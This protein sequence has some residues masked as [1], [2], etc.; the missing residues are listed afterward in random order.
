MT[1]RTDPWM[2]LCAD[3]AC[4]ACGKNDGTVV[5][6]HANEQR[7]GKGMGIK[8]D[9]WTVIALCA[10]HH[11][12]LDHIATREEARDA[13][14]KWW[15]FHMMGLCQAGLVAPIGFSEKV[16]PFRRLT[17]ILPRPEPPRAA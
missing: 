15:S 6:A 17:K 10:E 11:F 8:A 1:Y 7:F 13:W 16:K 3:R 9:S 5:A 2:A 4:V 12:W 14:A